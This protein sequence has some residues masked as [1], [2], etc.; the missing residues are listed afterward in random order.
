MSLFAKKGERSKDY[1]ALLANKSEAD[2][3]LLTSAMRQENVEIL[4]LRPEAVALYT[5]AE[6]DNAKDQLQAELTSRHAEVLAALKADIEAV[7]TGR[8][9]TAKNLR[10]KNRILEL[11]DQELIERQAELDTSLET[12]RS[13]KGEL[14]EQAGKMDRQRAKMKVLKNKLAETRAKLG[15]AEYKLSAFQ[16]EIAVKQLSETTRVETKIQAK[17]AQLALEN[18]LKKLKQ[19]LTESRKQLD[20]NRLEHSA[21]KNAYETLRREKKTLEDREDQVKDTLEAARNKLLQMRKRTVISYDIVE[22][23]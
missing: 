1:K 17:E 11:R 5:Q 21:L 23:H 16:D 2:I 20:Q 7:K 9:K 22:L 15:S 3:L 6:L 13:L 14:F 19:T 18:S 12:N 4:E 10:A 8:R